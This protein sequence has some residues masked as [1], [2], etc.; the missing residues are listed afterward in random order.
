[1]RKYLSVVTFLGVFT[2]S[3]MALAA[4]AGAATVAVQDAAPAATPEPAPDPVPAEATAPDLEGDPVGALTS[5]IDAI[6]ARNWAMVASLVLALAMLVLVKVRDK[7]KWFKGDRGGAL[8][9]MLLGLLGGFS[10][11]LAA[12]GATIDWRLVVGVVMAVWTAV[13]GVQWSK[14]VIW[15]KD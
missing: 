5:F 15:P 13:G 1:M 14:R 3:T 12:P 6:K 9:V 10:T 2:T 7:I 8:L 11:A 4:D